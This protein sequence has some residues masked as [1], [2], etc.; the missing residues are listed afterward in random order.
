MTYATLI[1]GIQQTGAVPFPISTRNSAVAIAHLVRSTDMHQMFV[2]EDVAMRTLASET[3]DLLAKNGYLVELLE[4]PR[5]EILYD[6]S[7]PVPTPEES[8][9]AP[10]SP[11]E[12]A[13][14]LHS[15]GTSAFPKPIRMNNRN[16]IAWGTSPC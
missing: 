13:M 15:S 3:T 12:P 5:F 11:K 14:I 6:Q 7:A 10:L 1:F 9:I 8:L 16:Y 2:S 4:F